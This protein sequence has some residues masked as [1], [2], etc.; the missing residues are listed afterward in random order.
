MA[1]EGGKVVDLRPT[2]SSFEVMSGDQ[3]DMIK[4]NF[5]F[6]SLFHGKVI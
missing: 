2:Q 1:H 5:F 3:Y 6:L 4:I